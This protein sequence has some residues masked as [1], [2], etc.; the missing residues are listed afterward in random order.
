MSSAFSGAATGP[1]SVTPGATRIDAATISGSASAPAADGSISIAISCGA[2]TPSRSYRFPNMRSKSSTAARKPNSDAAC[3]M[4]ATIV[5][6]PQ[7][8]DPETAQTIGAR[9]DGIEAS[10]DSAGADGAG[11]GD[12]D[13]GDN[14]PV[15]PA[16]VTR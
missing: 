6:L 11:T 5:D 2:S 13:A 7:P 14:I 10:A 12:T 4:V 16:A 3:A 15:S 9:R 8:P 1:Q